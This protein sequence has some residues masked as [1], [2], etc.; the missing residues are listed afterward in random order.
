MNARAIDA[1]ESKTRLEQEQ[2]QKANVQE[3]YDRLAFNKNPKLTKYQL[4]YI[5]DLVN[6]KA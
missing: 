6:T 1:L 2:K 3:V 5:E 4:P